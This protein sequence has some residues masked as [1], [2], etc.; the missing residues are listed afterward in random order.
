MPAV[1]ATG[2]D[3][4]ALVAYLQSLATPATG[5]APTPAPATTP[6]SSASSSKVPPVA[7]HPVAKIASPPAM[8]DSETKGKVMFEAHGCADYHRSGG[9]GG[10]AAAAALAGTGKGLAP[11]LLTTMLQHPTA[12]MQQ[13]GMPPVSLSTDELKALVAYVSQISGAKGNPQ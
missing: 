13:G 1:K 8:N 5:L 4:S 12:R 6:S 2:T 3:L 7:S 9:V 11:S 10:T